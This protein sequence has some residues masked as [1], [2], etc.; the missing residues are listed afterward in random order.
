[1]HSMLVQWTKCCYNGLPSIATL[2]VNI[3]AVLLH[4]HNIQHTHHNTTHTTHITH[5]THNMHTTHTPSI[6]WPL[7]VD[8]TQHT[9]NTHTP[10]IK[11][12][13]SSISWPLVVDATSIRTRNLHIKHP[14][15]L[16]TLPLLSWWLLHVLNLCI[17]SG[18]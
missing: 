17:I 18:L 1:M 9:C 2:H 15:A 4:T 12:R 8:S 7:V 10:L 16:T 14:K 13:N 11:L 3:I 6:S 5:N